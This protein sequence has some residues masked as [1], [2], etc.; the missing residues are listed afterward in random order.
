MALRTNGGNPDDNEVHPSTT[1]IPDNTHGA[2]LTPT[3]TS[4][5]THG[6]HHSAD[7]MKV[8]WSEY[9]FNPVSAFTAGIVA[10]IFFLIV[11]YLIFLSV[12]DPAMD[13]ALIVGG[14]VSPKLDWTARILGFGGLFGI[15]VS[16]SFV[17]GLA[18]LAFKMQSGMGKGLLYGMML[19]VPM[20]AFVLPFSLGFLARFGLSGA[21]IHTFDVMFNQVGNSGGQWQFA[22]WGLLAHMFF[23]SFLGLV[24]RHKE[25]EGIGSKYEV[26]YAG[27]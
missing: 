23:G 27:G 21:S 19:F 13:I 25:R 12:K 8:V 20:M 9:K 2:E 6:S 16:M 10:T 14:F 4:A 7:T 15:G 11:W 18:L 22:C 17:F 3:A 5:H 24:Y 26:E 1:G